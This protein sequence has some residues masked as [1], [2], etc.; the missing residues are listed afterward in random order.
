MDMKRFNP[1]NWLKHEEDQAATTLPIRKGDVNYPAPLSQ[2]HSEID[3][4][5]NDVFSGFGMPSL[6]A[7]VPAISKN[8]NEGFLRPQVDITSNEKSYEVTIEIPGVD[9]KDV[10]L[11]L[12]DQTLIVKG[13]KK[14]EKEEKDKEFYRMERSYGSFQRVLT[15]PADI[16]KE[17]ITATFKS[18]VL[19][20]SIPRMPT[21]KPEVKKIEIS[22][23]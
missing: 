17:D 23:S 8:L 15:L 21:P 4:L 7:G 5:F 14:Q 13:E 16:A 9:E 20:V 19:K 3:R 22:K 6:W 10:K 2:F 18:G 11:E 12:T 1:W